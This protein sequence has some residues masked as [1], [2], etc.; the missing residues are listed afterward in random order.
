MEESQ[1]GLK[2]RSRYTAYHY[3]FFKY[4]YNYNCFRYDNREKDRKYYRR[5]TVLMS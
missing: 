3:N 2:L 4:N 1:L 5:I